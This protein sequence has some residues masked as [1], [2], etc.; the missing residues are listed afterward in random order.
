MKNKRQKFDF[1]IRPIRN[2]DRAWVRE[3]ISRHWGSEKIISR[4]KI[5]YPHKLFGLVAFKDKKYL[6]LI[7]YNIKKGDCE[8]ITLNSVIKNK[9][10]GTILV[11]KVKEVAKKSGCRKLWLATTNDNIDTL[12]FWQ[13]IGLV[14]KSVYPNAI[15]RS[16]KLKP[17]IPYIGNYGIPIRDE[18]KL[19]LKIK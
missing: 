12:L 6:G 18:I 15:T 13:K 4:G 1:R 8:I 10:I 17:E 9:G 11:K 2:I 16:R 19:E 3:F 14:L 5:Y 7:T